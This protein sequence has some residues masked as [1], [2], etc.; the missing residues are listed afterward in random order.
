MGV[1]L[2]VEFA[3]GAGPLWPAAGEL[4]ARRGFPVQMRMIDGQLAFP[5]EAPPEGWR[6]LRLGTAAGMVTLRREPGGVAL[7]IWG[8]ADAPLMQARNALAW[9]CAEATGG[10]VLTESGRVSA[11]DFA[12]ADLQTGLR[13][14]GP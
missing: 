8:N 14:D 2:K 9:A 4:L 12:S 13:E 1:E 3:E 7:V 11:G 6:E 10:R 5:D